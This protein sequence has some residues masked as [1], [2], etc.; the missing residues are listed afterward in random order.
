[1]VQRHTLAFVIV[2][3]VAGASTGQGIGGIPGSSEN[4]VP[5][6]IGINVTVSSPHLWDERG[7]E[8]QNRER[9][10]RDR[11]AERRHAEQKRES[12]L[13]ELGLD[14]MHNGRYDRAVDFFSRLIDMH[15]RRADRAFYWRAFAQY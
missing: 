9:A 12:S 8:R 10:Q 4:G 6:G 1:M 11:E 7:R 5:R 13:Y 15:G 14:A 3:A 2:L